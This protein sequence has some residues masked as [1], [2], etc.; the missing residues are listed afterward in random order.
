MTDDLLYV[1]CYTAEAGGEGSG[2][3]CCVRDGVRLREVAVAVTP[4]PSYL[5][6]D[7]AAALLFAV[8]ETPQGAVSSFAIGPSGSLRQL[9][10]SP[11]GGDHP[12][13]LVLHSGQVL[14]A[15]YTSGSVSVHPVGPDGDL[16][17]RTDLVR[18]E[19]RGPNHDRQEAPHAHQVRVAHDGVVTVIDLG[20]DRLVHYR[21]DSGRLI[22]CGETVLPPGCGPRH[23]AI[24][25][26]GRWYV[27]GEMDS[28]VVVCAR[29]G[30]SG[31]LTVYGRHPTTTSTVDDDNLPSAV[32]LSTDG[33][34]L[35]VANRG[36]DTI[37]TFAVSEAGVLAPVA[38]VPCGG[39]WPRD[40]SVVGGL[41][42][43]ANQHSHT[44]TAFRLDPETGVPHPAG[45]VMEV[46]SPACVLPL[47]LG[48][49]YRYR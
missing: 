21:L 40:C 17:L 9:S 30:D 38:E 2:V 25:H 15:N 31:R 32:V 12:C 20:I 24:D 42:F 22:R 34:Y 29:A 14:A 1:G 37:A 7:P 11:T 39:E 19:G 45:T 18:H 4:S 47:Y 8:N 43:V 23:A 44:V 46:G 5:V 41:L 10:T 27:A 16:G 36:A 3:A 6:A 48:A 35:Y 26:R 13:H 49:G 33:R 28:T